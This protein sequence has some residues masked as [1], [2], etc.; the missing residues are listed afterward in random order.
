ME[1][2]KNGADVKDASKKKPCPNCGTMNP[3]KDTICPICPSLCPDHIPKSQ[4][5]AYFELKN[6]GR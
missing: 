3:H 1:L 4:M 6:K 5:K 2:V